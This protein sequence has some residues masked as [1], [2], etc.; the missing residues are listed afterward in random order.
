LED[1]QRLVGRRDDGEK[2][3]RKEEEISLSNLSYGLME[4]P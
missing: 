3:E 1:G 2:E 4:R